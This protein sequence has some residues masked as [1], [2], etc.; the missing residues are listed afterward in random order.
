MSAHERLATPT[1]PPQAEVSDVR[2]VGRRA[3]R[4]A[5]PA[6]GRADVPEL[7]RGGGAVNVRRICRTPEECYAAGRDDGKHDTPLTDAEIAQMVA[8][9]ARY[10]LADTA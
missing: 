9:H 2:R 6:Q 5:R 3:G 7:R 8:L 10:L 4:P 1:A